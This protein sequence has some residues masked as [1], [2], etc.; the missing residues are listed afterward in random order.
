MMAKGDPVQKVGVHAKPE[1]WRRPWVTFEFGGI[2][3]SLWYS[4][5][6][7]E[8]KESAIWS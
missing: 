6:V 5:W 4:P 7:D 3:S 8:D 2:F 1:S